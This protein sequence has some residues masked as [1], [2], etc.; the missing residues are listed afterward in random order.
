MN[1]M[2][3]FD[4][5]YDDEEYVMNMME[6]TEE[7]NACYTPDSNGYT[8]TD[9]EYWYYNKM[10]LD[11]PQSPPV[12]DPAEQV[13]QD[14]AARAVALAFERSSPPLLGNDLHSSARD[15]PALAH[16][17]PSQGNVLAGTANPPVSAKTRVPRF[18]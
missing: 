15:L 18:G 8:A 7:N 14:A 17:H 3:D 16:D 6:W 4:E 10:D 9:W 13:L 1:A 12:Y 11:A 2:E 5:Q